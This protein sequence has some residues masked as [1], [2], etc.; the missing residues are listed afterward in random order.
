MK[1]TAV[2]S[3]PEPAGAS[4]QFAL[5]QKPW[6]EKTASGF[7]GWLEERGLDPRPSQIFWYYEQ[8][9]SSCAGNGDLVVTLRVR[10]LDLATPYVLRASYG[11][12]GQATYISQGRTE[13]LAFELD[14]EKSIDFGV[15]TSAEW[16]GDVYDADGNLIAAPAITVT[17]QTATAPQPVYGVLEVQ[18][19]EELYE[20]SLTIAPRAPSAD[21]A[22]RMADGDNVFPELYASTAMLF[23]AQKIALLKA[24]MPDDFGTC[25]GAPTDRGDTPDDD[26]EE[27]SADGWY[28]VNFYAFDYCQGTPLG[29]FEVWINGQLVRDAIT[30]PGGVEHTIR[31]VA[32]GYT[33]SDEDDLQDNDTF[34]LPGSI[35]A[36]YE[37]AE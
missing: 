32:A 11:E 17:G 6:P 24:D 25:D 34:T 31:V 2:I 14:T 28:S 9:K 37:P 33:P 21:Q 3:F 29:E 20:H 18:V 13:F 12:I 30:L 5:V 22:A 8:Y 16:N 23:C 35:P 10:L 27:P 15:I 1:T 36:D 7:Q 19:V 4:G 26:D